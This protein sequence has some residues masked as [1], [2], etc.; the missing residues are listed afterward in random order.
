MAGLTAGQL[1][2]LIFSRV[3]E[4]GAMWSS[5]QRDLIEKQAVKTPAQPVAP[6]VAIT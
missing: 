5:L 1:D 3:G 6:L 2:V 4:T